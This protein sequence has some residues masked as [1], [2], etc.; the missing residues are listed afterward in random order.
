MTKLCRLPLLP[1]AVL[2]ELSLLAA[3][4]L[5]ALASPSAACAFIALAKQ[6]PDADWYMGRL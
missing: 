1:F 2:V 5:L 3:A 4:W 6:L